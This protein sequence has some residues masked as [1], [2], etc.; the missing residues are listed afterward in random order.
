MFDPSRTVLVWDEKQDYKPN[1]RKAEFGEYKGNRSTDASPHQ[2][3]NTI[4]TFTSSLG[5]QSIYPRELEADDIVAY[6]CKNYSGKNIIV[7]VDKDFLQLVNKDTSL[8]DPIRKTECTDLNF[9]EKTGYPDV[10]TWLEVK[11]LV[12]D[13]SDNVPGIPKFGKHKIKKYLEGNL[14]LTS[15]EKVIYERNYALFNLNRINYSVNESQ[16]YKDQ[17]DTTINND[18]KAFIDLCSAYNFNS[19][20]KKKDAWY[21]RFFLTNKLQS[22]FS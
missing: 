6:I 11:C 22:L 3:N 5:I 18:W 19:I 1:S 20:L 4:K 17:L 9:Q 14:V 8:Y 13:K 10:K 12:G 21:S 15:E 16:Y 2:N 7:S